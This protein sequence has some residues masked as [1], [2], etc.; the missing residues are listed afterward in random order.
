MPRQNRVTPFA[1]RAYSA[2]AA[3]YIP[4]LHPSTQTALLQPSTRHF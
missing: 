1:Q 2:L 3:G 4:N